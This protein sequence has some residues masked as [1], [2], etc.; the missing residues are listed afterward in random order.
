LLPVF[1]LA[2]TLRVEASTTVSTGVHGDAAE[3]A[4]LVDALPDAVQRLLAL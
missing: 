3:Q 2:T 4:P 1:T